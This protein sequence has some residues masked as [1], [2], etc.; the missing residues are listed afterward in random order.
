MLTIARL[1]LLHFKIFGGETV[2]KLE[3]KAYG[4][5]ARY[6]G[7][8]ARSNWAG[9]TTLT[10][11]V[12][13]C[14]TG[15]RPRDAR[16]KS[17]W[18]T[19]GEEKGEVDV[20]LSDGTRVLRTMSRKGSER[21]YVFP[22][23][24]PENGAVQDA[25]QTRIDELLG[26]T[27]ADA[28]TWCFRQGE[29]AALLR[30]DPAVRLE[31]FS[32]WFRLGALEEC[33]GAAA[34]ARGAVEKQRA[35]VA[36]VLETWRNTRQQR[37]DLANL[38]PGQTFAEA[39][40]LAEVD[41]A[42][43][44]R[45]VDLYERG[46][47]RVRERA[48]LAADAARHDQIV[49][50][51]QAVAQQLR[52]MASA[53]DLEVERAKV[54][55][56]VDEY[57]AEARKATDAHRTLAVVASGHFDG[58]C[59]IAGAACP[60]A[61]FV[62]ST[63]QANVSATEEARARLQQWQG[64]LVGARDRQMFIAAKIRDRERLVNRLRE[65]RAAVGPL[66]E[67]KRRW[68]A[69]GELPVADG[70]SPL[71]L[72]PQRFQVARTRLGDLKAAA[73]AV[74]A[75]DAKIA[76]A[77]AEVARLEKVAEIP[78][79]AALVFEKARRQ[80]AEGVLGEIEEHANE[81]LGAVGA[82][83][84]V[85]ITWAREGEGLADACGGCGAAFPASRKVKDCARCGAA[86]GQ[87]I[88]ERI[89]ITPSRR[90]GAAD[91]FGGVAVTLGAS[92][93]LREDRESEWGTATIDEATSQMDA[94]NRRAFAVRLPEILRLAGFEQALLVSHH[95]ETLEALPGRIE[96][97]SKDGRSTARVVA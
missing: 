53:E 21:L 5:F 20:T 95:R 89:D 17:D 24:D 41:Y 45:D 47:A 52:E 9:K 59:P 73:L 23:G 57:S 46:A 82:D 10:E 66:V 3:P 4:I 61:A 65:F 62:T 85:A 80:I 6:V 60:S 91:D 83:L 94:A 69:L 8:D 67:R 77:E 50:D 34:A 70:S 15:R 32:G 58:Q 16:L 36:R 13:Y 42:N 56:E 81:I 78:A 1:R 11:A 64:A 90:S 22:P 71:G 19:E 76:E 79:A 31:M 7:D 14:L 51:G 93:W 39:I 27:K 84:T 33:Q 28:S 86:R 44:E 18:I 2:L 92:R 72:A 12:D 26:L 29:M 43:A 48:E 49:V 25:A 30:M 37:V 87:K 40:D 75:A 88:T 74:G 55:T 54:A 63:V 68:Q 96:V 38:A 35:E 97:V